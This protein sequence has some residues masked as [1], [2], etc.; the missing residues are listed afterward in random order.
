MYLTSILNIIIIILILVIIYYVAYDLYT[1]IR[2][3]N[4]ISIVKQN[5]RSVLTNMT[6]KSHRYQSSNTYIDSTIVPWKTLINTINNTKIYHSSDETYTVNDGKTLYLDLTAN[7]DTIMYVMAHELAHMT[8]QTHRNFNEHNSLD[9][10]NL[11][12][13]YRRN[14]TDNGVLKYSNVSQNYGKYNNIK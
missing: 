10:T 12:K 3:G 4:R 9:F 14:M 13:K 6:E 5:C 8:L 7:M 1:Y 2:Y 11:M